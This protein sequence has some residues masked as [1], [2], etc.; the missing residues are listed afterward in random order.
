MLD[1]KFVQYGNRFDELDTLRV[2]EKLRPK[3]FENNDFL[4]FYG[5]FK[6]LNLD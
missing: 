1:K 6:Q 2:N 4:G 3:K 5:N